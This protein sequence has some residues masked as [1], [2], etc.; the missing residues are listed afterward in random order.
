[1][2]NKAIKLSA[3]FYLEKGWNTNRNRGIDYSKEKTNMYYVLTGSRIGRCFEEA[4]RKITELIQISAYLVVFFS[5]LLIMGV[6]LKGSHLFEPKWLHS[7]FI[8]EY[9]FRL[10]IDGGRG[11]I[12]AAREDDTFSY[13]WHTAEN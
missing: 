1:M 10:L 3:M 11:E 12:P 2:G 9:K 7:I 13:I 4:F 8:D 6:W 5:F